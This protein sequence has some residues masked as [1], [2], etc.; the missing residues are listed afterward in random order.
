MD[1]NRP[2]KP[3]YKFTPQDGHVRRDDGTWGY[4]GKATVVDDDD[5]QGYD[6]R[7]IPGGARAKTN[8]KKGTGA[9]TTTK[10]P[11]SSLTPGMSYKFG[12]NGTLVP[13]S[14]VMPPEPDGGGAMLKRKA[15]HSPLVSSAADADEAEEDPSLHPSGALPQR[16]SCLD[17]DAPPAAR[18]LSALHQRAQTGAPPPSST[19]PR[20][21]SSSSGGGRARKVQ[22]V[23]PTRMMRTILDAD[24][25][26]QRIEDGN[27]NQAY[28]T[29]VPDGRLQYDE[30]EA[31]RAQRAREREAKVAARKANA[32]PS[33][34]TEAE[35]AE[36]A[37]VE[38]AYMDWLL[39]APDGRNREVDFV[40]QYTGFA[41][42]LRWMDYL[43]RWKWHKYNGF[44]AFARHKKLYELIDP[45]TA[46]LCGKAA[47]RAST[48]ADAPHIDAQRA[49]KARKK[50]RQKELMYQAFGTDSEEEEFTRGLAPGVHQGLAPAHPARRAAPCAQ[51]P[52][53]GGAAPARQRQGQ[54]GL[55]LP[56]HGAVDQSGR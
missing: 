24:E 14:V 56:V 29:P 55:S 23:P 44:E 21:S 17:A 43:G 36:A 31:F 27:L 33:N 50:A 22:A 49:Q 13:L 1:Q 2:P 16:P 20:P 18:L 47:V 7:P 38:V 32:G 34:Y 3:R 45:E 35:R 39:G 10:A 9:Q 5:E 12:P 52:G 41:R 48:G 4:V 30:P 6:D 8:K 53:L 40:L 51:A 46:P 25:V 28:L 11:S 26:R 54:Q 19:R 37:R 15:S 42:T